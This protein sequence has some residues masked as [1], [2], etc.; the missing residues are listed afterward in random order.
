MRLSIARVSA[1]GDHTTGD[2]VIRDDTGLDIRGAARRRT[3][4]ALAVALILGC[5][6]LLF[7]SSKPA[8]ADTP[9]FASGQVFASV[10]NSA[11]NVYSQGAGNPLFP[12]LNVGLP[13]PSPA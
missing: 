12:P 5:I 6:G 3:A 8:G 10:G 2:T 13:G 1:A 4:L 11:V 7:G 9:V